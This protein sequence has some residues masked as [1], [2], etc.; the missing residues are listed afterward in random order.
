[1][2]II[3]RLYKLSEPLFCFICFMGTEKCVYYRPLVNE[4]GPY[5]YRIKQTMFLT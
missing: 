5:F 4:L 2:C 3:L 1:M